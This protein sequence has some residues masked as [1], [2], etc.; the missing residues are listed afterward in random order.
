MCKV[1]VLSVFI[2]DLLIQVIL[3]G[4]LGI[5]THLAFYL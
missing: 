1:L 5:F 3:P 4:Y 2:L